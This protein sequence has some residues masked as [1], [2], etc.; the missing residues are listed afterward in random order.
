MTG[1]LEIFRPRELRKSRSFGAAH[2]KKSTSEKRRRAVIF[3]TPGRS[4]E[5]LKRKLPRANI[6]LKYERESY[7]KQIKLF[8]I[9]ATCVEA[10]S[11]LSAQSQPNNPSVPGSNPAQAPNNP[12]N[13]NNPSRPNPPAP[14][15]PGASSGLPALSPRPGISPITSSP[16]ASIAPLATPSG[17]PMASPT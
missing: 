1:C 12:N 8:G 4:Q 2:A 5:D 15:V 6:N 11:F 13:P 16:G 7:M 3:Y 14:H 10:L 9:L 17:S